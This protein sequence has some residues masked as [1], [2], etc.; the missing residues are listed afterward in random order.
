VFPASG[1]EHLVSA[2]EFHRHQKK[3]VDVFIADHS[4]KRYKEKASARAALVAFLPCANPKGGCDAILR[5]ENLPTEC[6]PSVGVRCAKCLYSFCA[7]CGEEEH[8]PASCQQ[9]V[10]WTAKCQGDSETAN[11]ILVNTKNCPNCTNRTEKNGGCNH[12]TCTRCKAEWCWVCHGS[13]AK[14]GSSFYQCNFFQEKK[15]N[16][17]T[18]EAKK[19]A[20]AKESLERYLHYFTRYRNHDESKK[21]DAKVLHQVQEKTRSE[22]AR[23]MTALDA[24]YLEQ[25]AHTLSLCRHTLKYSYVHAFFLAD[26]P[27][28]LKLFEYNQGQL[29]FATEQL[30]ELIEAARVD[31][32]TVIDKTAVAAKMLKNLQDGADKKE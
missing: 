25:T 20:T 6:P 15:D 9:V 32:L 29:E 11:W 1:W 5:L 23:G 4:F 22:I 3:I 28:N 8:S 2:D 27:A 13:W 14:H 31:R 17:S 19:K 21:L 24:E 18:I 16:E 10:D 7:A 30:S 12:M 26:T